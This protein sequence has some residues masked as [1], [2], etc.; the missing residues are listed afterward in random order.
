MTDPYY[1]T[2]SDFGDETHYWQGVDVTVNARL[3]N[4]LLVQGE[5]APAAA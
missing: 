5:R 2:A 3:S 4:G 1:T